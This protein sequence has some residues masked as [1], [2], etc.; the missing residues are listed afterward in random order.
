MEYKLR[1]VFYE[2]KS[3]C[4]RKTNPL[5]HRYGGR[6]I[7]ICKSWL[8]DINKFISW[9]ENNGYKDTLTIDRINNDG[10]YSPKNCRWITLA[11][12]GKNKSNSKNFI[13]NGT[14]MNL[15]DI[16][17]KY[18]ISY[19]VLYKRLNKGASIVEAINKNYKKIQF[20]KLLNSYTKLINTTSGNLKAISVKINK[21]KL[22]IE[23]VCSCGAVVIYH[24]SIFLRR[25]CCGSIEC[26][27]KAIEEKRGLQTRDPV[28][29]RFIKK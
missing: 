18:K 5:Y 12:N 29:Q 26:T 9:A 2:M 22:K 17:K 4:Y 7:V 8:S 15:S 6:G 19:G 14:Q 13:I 23:A 1:R 20:S 24:P 11:E 16:A 10:N 25:K 3:R 28:T 27:K 21:D